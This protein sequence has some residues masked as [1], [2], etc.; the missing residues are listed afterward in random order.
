MRAE[1]GGSSAA[2]APAGQ[3]WTPVAR[4]HRTDA[5]L[6]FA[7]ELPGVAA[8]RVG[9]TTAHDVLTIHATRAPRRSRSSDTRDGTPERRDDHFAY[10][11]SL[12]AGVDPASIRADYGDGLLA[13]HVP[14]PSRFRRTAITVVRVRRPAAHGRRGRAAARA[15]PTAAPARPPGA[16]AH[17]DGAPAPATIS[18]SG[19]YVLHRT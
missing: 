5:E 17:G 9:V 2:D 18:S 1:H 13:V 12:P 16:P 11:F 4:V 7:L 15:V 19:D 3:A 14:N 8:D 6:T 10:R